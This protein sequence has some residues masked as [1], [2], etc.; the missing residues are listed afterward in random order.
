MTD[1]HKKRTGF[2]QSETLN[3]WRRMLAVFVLVTLVFAIISGIGKTIA[4]GKI[5]G[6]ST[7]DGNSSVSIIRNTNPP[8]ILIWQTYPK[9][10]IVLT[11]D[12]DLKLVIGDTWRGVKGV[13]EIFEKLSGAEARKVV[14]SGIHVPIT[15]YVYFEKDENRHRDNF[16]DE[17]RRFAAITTP[18]SILVYGVG[19]VDTDIARMDIIRLWWQVKSLSVDDIEIVDSTAMTEN[20]ALS[21]GQKVLGVDDV[22][23]HALL[24]KYM[25]NRKILESSQK[26]TII[27]AS[28]VSGTGKLA[29]DF[30]SA[31]GG[32]V[33]SVEAA[34]VVDVTSM[35]AEKSYTSTY[36]AKLFDCVITS[37][38]INSRGSI[39]I[40]IGRDF[41]Q[42]YF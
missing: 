5:L 29:S 19:D 40:V 13:G 31:V 15:N 10:L 8:S 33:E 41:A 4:F 25:E 24:S 21:G 42:K 30:V 38:P 28:G 11:L 16:E 14:A 26:V 32:T 6:T 39:R 36:L 35:I 3:K 17:F 34:D 18:L 2:G 7:W 12:S 20:V 22:S 23:M 37:G 27:N 1:Y 9:R